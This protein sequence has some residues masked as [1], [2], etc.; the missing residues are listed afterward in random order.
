[1]ESSNEPI[2]N[3]IIGCRGFQARTSASSLKNQAVGARQGN[4][5]GHRINFVSICYRVHC[6]QVAMHAADDAAFDDAAPNDAASDD[7]ASNDTAP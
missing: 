4:D 1:M 5:G 6:S 7:A 3:D 2:N